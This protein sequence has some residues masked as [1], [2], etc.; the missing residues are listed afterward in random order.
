MVCFFDGVDPQ[1]ARR[2]IKAHLSC[3]IAMTMRSLF[4]LGRN[5]FQCDLEPLIYLFNRLLVLIFCKLSS[6]GSWHQRERDRPHF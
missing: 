3:L 6:G 1:A 2:F 4:S 5:F